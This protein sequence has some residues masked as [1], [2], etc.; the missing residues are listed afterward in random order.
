MPKG[1]DDHVGF[2]ALQSKQILLASLRF[3]CSKTRWDSV[4][5]ARAMSAVFRM[6][7]DGVDL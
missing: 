3:S 7:L 5:G 1:T 6:E 4:L 2:F